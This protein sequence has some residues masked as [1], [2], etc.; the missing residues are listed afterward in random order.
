[1]S[2]TPHAGTPLAAVAAFERAGALERLPGAAGDEPFLRLA[3]GWLLGHPAR[4]A[5]AYRRDLGA[6]ARWCQQ[7]GTDPLAAQ[8]HH[9]DAWVRHLSAV[10]RPA[11]GR[12]ASAATIA[13]MLSA[14][15]GFY[16]YGIDQGVLALSPV[17][18]VRRP[19]VSANSTTPGLDAAQL[20]ALLAAAAAHST[21]SGALVALLV[22]CGLRISEA[23]GADVRDYGHDGG[24][25]VLA[26]VRKGGIAARVP[27][28]PPVVRILDA[29]LD[30]R[31]AGPIFTAADE[32][33][34]YPYSSAYEQIRRLCA[35]AGLPAG[36]SPHSLRHSYATEALRLGAPL[37][38][39][40]DALGHADPRT[41]R[42]YDRAR[43]L[44]DRSP[45]YLLATALHPA[46]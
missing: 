32:T 9:V 6:W 13:R 17:A 11:T 20:R 2:L 16:A 3:A 46:Q 33:S 29:H 21:R 24:H 40:Q 19:R 28:P 44:L 15:S 39:V 30:G 41:T 5:T 10:P 23:L 7:M 35:A 18:A 14:I 27:L 34:Q 42:R 26:I 38:D 36:I 22:L 37:Q 12:V 45:N 1:M 25:R 43:Y 4:T 8:R 31:Q